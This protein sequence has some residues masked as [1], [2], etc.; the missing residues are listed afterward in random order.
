MSAHGLAGGCTVLGPVR[1]RPARAR[2]APRPGPGL[3]RLDGSGLAALRAGALVTLAQQLVPHLGRRCRRR[4]PATSPAS[5]ALFTG[6]RSQASCE[7]AGNRKLATV[8]R[9]SLGPNFVQHLCIRLK[10]HGHQPAE[11]LLLID[12]QAAVA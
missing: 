8:G 3:P 6:I 10:G 2:S 4:P 7:I 12:F 1:K 11:V 5:V 9:S